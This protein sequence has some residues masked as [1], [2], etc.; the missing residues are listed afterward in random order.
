MNTEKFFVV[1]GILLFVL[2]LNSILVMLCWNAFLIPAIV[3]VNEI[4]FI[5]AMGITGLFGILFKDS[6]VKFKNE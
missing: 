5:Q 2:T 6:G 4:G 1:T 3:G